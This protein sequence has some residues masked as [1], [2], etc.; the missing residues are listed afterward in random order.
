MNTNTAPAGVNDE[1]RQDSILARLMA[2]AATADASL[3]DD[4]TEICRTI[5]DANQVPAARIFAHLIDLAAAGY[6]EVSTRRMSDAALAALV[7]TI[8]ALTSNQDLL[9]DYVPEL[10]DAVRCRAT[11][12][13]V[14][15]PEGVEVLI[16]AAAVVASVWVQSA[17]LASGETD[18]TC[19]YDRLGE[20]A[21][22]LAS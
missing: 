1:R 22:T 20:I 21:L 16:D 13:P 19:T 10:M 9:G 15:V 17:A 8:G 6:R 18:G 11:G 2:E 14:A 7:D 4:L 5:I 12:R 3:A